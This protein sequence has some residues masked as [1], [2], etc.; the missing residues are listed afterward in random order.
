MTRGGPFVLAALLAPACWA[1]KGDVPPATVKDQPP[2]AEYAPVTKWANPPE[3]YLPNGEVNPEYVA[4]K[5]KMM[6]S[7]EP[8]TSEHDTRAA[9]DTPPDFRLPSGE[10]NP[11]YAAWKK[12]YLASLGLAPSPEEQ[13]PAE[14]GPEPRVVVPAETAAVPPAE[15]LVQPSDFNRFTNNPNLAGP[16]VEENLNAALTAAPSDPAVNG[17]LGV[18]DFRRGN[19]ERAYQR[20][21]TAIENGPPE[22]DLY[23]LRGAS[24][25]NLGRPKE[26]AADLGKAVQLKPDQT[27]AQDLLKLAQGKVS[28]RVLKLPPP[29][30]SSSEPGPRMGPRAGAFPA[31]PSSELPQRSD[32]L[33]KE[34]ASRMRIKDYAGAAAAL[35]KAL[36]VNPKDDAARYVRADALLRAGSPKEAEAEAGRVLDSVPG[37]AGALNIR[38]LARNR[39]GDFPGALAD[40]QAALSAKADSALAFYN[41]AYALAG[42]GQRAQSLTALQSA[43]RLDPSFSP[44][45]QRLA[46]LPADAD[47]L[48]VFDHPGKTAPEAAPASGHER[49][50]ARLV[51]VAGGVLTAAGLLFLWKRRER[52]APAAAQARPRRSSDTVGPGLVLGGQ[53]RVDGE[54]GRGSMGV[55]LRATDLNLKRPVAV[56]LLRHD[57]LGRPELAERFLREAQLAAALKH[58]N[59]VQIHTAFQEGADIALVFELVNGNPLSKV[60]KDFHHLSLGDAKDVVRQTASALDYAH[61]RRVIHRDLKPANIMVGPDGTASVMDLGLAFVAGS[62]DAPG[63]WGT[64]AYMAP[65]QELGRPAA[66]SDIYA[67]GVTLYEM[68][69]GSVPFPGPDALAQKKAMAFVAP[70]VREARLPKGLDAVIRR[71]LEASPEARYRTA[72]EL[73]AALDALPEEAS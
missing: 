72:G 35:D 37:H 13:V 15:A 30:S 26:A 9:L 43:A 61:A 17:Y 54:L 34:A 60:I 27:Q 10:P 63:S 31:D 29:S 52:E 69:T 11:A 58:P 28:G 56:K 49:L 36:A 68:L 4:W 20:F 45:E 65:E 46:V 25:L 51:G 19:F 66:A 57:S 16:R 1:G 62:G 55:V 38:A 3:P 41:L 6:F 39:G 53:Y 73:A 7:P 67:L 50:P 2:P 14:A 12:K 18:I 70:S 47:A 8:A 40:A 22:P 42:L 21:N 5:R 32:Y 64:P 44:A 33:F 48:I 24:A 59:I 71:A 23:Y